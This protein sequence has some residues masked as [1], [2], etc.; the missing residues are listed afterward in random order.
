MTLVICPLCG[1]RKARRACPALR[2]EICA[3]CCG[4]KRLTEI[5]CP[6][7]CG[8]LAVSREHPAAAV[9]R[10]R[11]RDLRALVRAVRDFGDRQSRLFFTTAAYV[12]RYPAPDL[13]PLLD[14]DVA[15]AAG[16]LAATYETATRGVIYEH[17]PESVPAERLAASLKPLL[18]EAGK[19]GG[20][21][22]ERDAALVLRRIEEGVREAR[23]A[24]TPSPRAYLDFL[25]RVLKGIVQEQDASGA[26][27]GGSTPNP[28]NPGSTDEPRLIVQP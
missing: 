20:T 15:E 26:G 14:D 27:G 6:P 1:I 18:D 19:G 24:G 17:R 8:Y 28:G 16:A 12:A 7:D 21:A 5:A 13:H 3:V 11:E 22:F 25:A 9:V 4:T 10:Q 23:Q 2:Q